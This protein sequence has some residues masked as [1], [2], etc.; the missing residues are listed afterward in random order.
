MRFL[1]LL[2]AALPVTLA[3]PGLLGPDFN[4]DIL[5]KLKEKRHIEERQVLTGLT[6]TLSALGSTI[7]GLLGSVAAEVTLENL[8]PEPGYDFIAPG[9]NDSR[10]P[11]P[12]LNLLANHG[13]LPRNGLVNYGQVLEATA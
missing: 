2:L 9:T 5:T 7:K 8:R 3:Y 13:Y 1:T 10:G 6:G 12:G 11:C 4:E